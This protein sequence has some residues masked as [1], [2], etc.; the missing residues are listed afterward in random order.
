MLGDLGSSYFVIFCS[1]SRESS[2]V[3]AVELGKVKSGVEVDLIRLI[4]VVGW[5]GWLRSRSS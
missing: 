4:I 1:A 5:R 3:A 2:R